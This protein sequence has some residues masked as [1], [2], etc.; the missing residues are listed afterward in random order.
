MLAI[1]LVAVLFHF[2]VL[3]TPEP[4][5]DATVTGCDAAPVHLSGAQA[6]LLRLHNEARQGHGLGTFCVSEPLTRAATAHSQDML[7]R[8]YYDHVSPEGGTPA[9]RVEA[10]G[11]AYSAMAE[12]IHKREISYPNEPTRKDL[13][14]VFEDWMDSPG[15]RANL[16]NPE[17]REVGIGAAFGNYDHEVVTT[18]LY[19][20]EFGTP[21]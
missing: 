4:V 2:D 14:Q 10:A 16:L 13:E 8:G 7:N 11:Y 5:R 6:E 19:T 3:N 1:G 18:G 12:N 20:V 17:L 15:H 9:Q 21:R